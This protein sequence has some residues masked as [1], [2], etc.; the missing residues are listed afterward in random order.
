MNYRTALRLRFGKKV[1]L[2]AA[3]VAA[4]AV[5]IAIGI[6]DAPQI[7]AQSAE[8]RPA[9]EVASIKPG[10]ASRRHGFPMLAGA[11]VVATN[12]TA[13]TL[14]EI[15][16]DVRKPQ[17]SGGPNWLDSEGFDIEAKSAR[18][19]SGPQMRL[20]LQSLLADRF[21]LTLHRETREQPVYDLVVAKGGPKLKAADPKEAGALRVGKGQVTGMKAPMSWLAQFLSGEAL[22]RLVIDQTGLGGEYDF[23]LQWTPDAS[24][25]SPSIF[26][27]V[28]EQ[29]G[30]QLRAEKGPVEVLV[31]DRLEKPSAN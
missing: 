30:L 2:G 26:T 4:I 9:F 20:M 13:K 5:P 15:A 19:L 11:R 28:Q 22:D 21:K 29:L 27:A 10:D 1:L 3:T 6:A 16:Y 24:A 12:V 7:R 23:T 31:V 8:S 25:D 18:S 17:V 14:I